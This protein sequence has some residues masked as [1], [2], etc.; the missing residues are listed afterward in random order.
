MR[1]PALSALPGY[2]RSDSGRKLV[3][4]GL[5]SVINVVVAEAVLAFAFGVLAWP[6][7]RAAVLAAV[8][9]AFPAYW[10]ARRWVWGR[11]GRSHLMK[12]IV[13]FWALA[14]FGMVLNT[15]VAGVAETVGARVTA[16]R[17]GQTVILMGSVL[18]VSM[19]FWAVRF[20][21]LN[22]ILFADPAGAPPT[23]PSLSGRSTEGTGR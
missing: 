6:A 20:F 8:V 22:G 2:L 16:S 15:W 9:A 23:E 4:Y 7:R 21:L 18:G 14:L 19:A 17:L 13:P 11:S 3:R 12:E 10:L 5:A 1:T